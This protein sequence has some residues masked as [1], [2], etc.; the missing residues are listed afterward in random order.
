MKQWKTFLM[1]RWRYV[2]LCMTIPA[3]AP[4]AHEIPVHEAI[5]RNAAESAFTYSS[6]YR[7]FLTMVGVD[8]DL[9]NATNSLVE[10][11]AKEDN[12]PK[13]DLIG[14]YRSYNHFYDPLT[15]LGLSDIPPDRRISPFGH[16][17]FTWSS[18]LN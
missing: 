4:L 13:Q 17:S 7:D 10:G 1:Q 5:T 16:N 6:A 8:I 11:S 9:K 3:T 18:T 14:G 12:V 15:G 2:A